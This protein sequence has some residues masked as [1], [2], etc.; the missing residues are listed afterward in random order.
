M[1]YRINLLDR[2]LRRIHNISA[3]NG[4]HGIQE[5]RFML[6]D[7]TTAKAN[8]SFNEKIDK[9]DYIVNGMNFVQQC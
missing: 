3:I 6:L 7:M 9:V 5:T 8:Y 4:G 2:V 1:V